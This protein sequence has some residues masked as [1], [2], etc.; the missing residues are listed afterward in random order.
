MN[1]NELEIKVAI[2]ILT[3]LMT[4]YYDKEIPKQ[5][6]FT[7]PLEEYKEQRNAIKTLIILAQQVL[8]VK[9]FPLE[10]D[11]IG[12]P[13]LDKII[14]AEN[15]MIRKC[16]IYHTKV[17]MELNKEIADLHKFVFQCGGK[18]QKL[19]QDRQRLIEALEKIG[20]NVNDCGI[21]FVTVKEVLEEVSK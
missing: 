3:L 17:V 16:K 18:E 1:L 21:V 13:T 20:E 11:R 15:E 14:E 4:N 7:D 12:L 5:T 6:T 10:Q 2:K 19:Q 9:G 8:D